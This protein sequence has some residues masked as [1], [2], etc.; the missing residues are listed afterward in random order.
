VLSQSFK[1]ILYLLLIYFVF[2]QYGKNIVQYDKFD[3]HFIQ[4]EHFDIYYSS[5]GEKNID[6]VASFS[7]EAYDKISNLIG[8]D[9]KHRSSII[10]YNSHNEFQQT[11]VIESYMREGIGGVTEL[12]KN[13]M[14]VPYDGSM[15]DFEQVIYHELVH[16]FINDGVYGG[17]LQSVINSNTVFIPL[18][19]NEGLA[20]YLSST[21]DTN[22][23]MWIRDLAINAKTLPEIKDLNG[24]FAYRGGQSLWKFICEK[25][26]EEVIAEIFYS[27]KV[28]KDINKGIK[29]ATGV[30][31]KEL[32]NQWHKYLKKEYWPDIAIRDDVQD[33][34]RQ[35]TDHTKLNN[36]YNIA[37]SPSP[38]GTKIAI[39][40]N[41]DGEMGIYI[42]SAVDG[43][44]IKRIVR[45]NRIGKFEELHF[46]KP[47]IS[48]SPEGENI[49]FSGKSDGDDA[50]FIYEIN[51]KKENFSIIKVGLKG[52][53]KPVWNPKNNKIAFIGNNGFSSDVYVYDLDT[54][55]LINLTNDHFSDIQIAWHPNGESLLLV[56]D[57]QNN[58]FNTELLDLNLLVDYNFD[59][60]DIFKIN[61][62]GEIDRI[63]DTPYNESYAT[64]SPNG[65]QIAYLSD[66]SGIN[67]IY[68]ISEDEEK[69]KPATNVSTGI[70][71]L[72][73]L[74]NNKLVFT[75]F[76]DSAYDIFILS[77]IKRALQEVK[78]VPLAKWRNKEKLKLLRKSNNNKFDDNN[79]SNF[80]F[81]SDNLANRDNAISFDPPILKDNQGKYK[82]YKYLT[83]F[84]LDYA[85]AFY[86]FDSYYG[87]AGMG[88]FLFSDILGDHRAAVGIELQSELEESD[89]F[90][91][92]RYLKKKLNHEGQLYNRAQKT[93]VTSGSSDGSPFF[94]NYV[95][96][97]NV[98]LDYRASY[99]FS[100]F[101]RLEGGINYN[102]YMRE[103]YTWVEANNEYAGYNFSDKKIILPYAK[104]VFDNTRWFYIHPV[105]GSRIYVK[106]DVA[107]GN[108]VNNFNYNMLTFDSRSYFELSY[109]GKISLAARIYGGSSWGENK[110]KYAIGGVPWLASSDKD[111]ISV[112]Y[113][114]Y[115][116]N[117]D[118]DF[119][120]MNNFVLP[121]RGHELGSRYGNKALLMNFELRLPMLV[122]YFPAIEYLGQIFG[123]FFVDMGV[124]WDDH[125]PKYNDRDSWDEP[126]GPEIDSIGDPI[127]H[128]DHAAGWVMSYG[129]GPRFIFFGMPWKLDYAW[130]YDPYEGKKSERS[131][132]L[133]IG[134]DF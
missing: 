107:P 86:T 21:W 55:L 32:T 77:N 118:K 57:R 89:Y 7:E 11:N 87:S 36:S 48:W 42:L 67:N 26:G 105:S 80:I 92:Y 88:V 74:S 128:P 5:I 102:Y 60:L 18:W 16:V 130:Q 17:S 51:S 64:Y 90:I 13:R 113:E 8:W 70:S 56:S 27:I 83:R 132:Y 2:P 116:Y 12:M 91:Q 103:D 9:L 22:S 76:Y 39:Y 126:E 47:G 40:S 129:L 111:K 81:S 24:Y 110:R 95:L 28:K 59:N 66:K 72:N 98:G 79:L 31:L 73:W 23:D 123:V 115:L 29:A 10:F 54:K 30:D 20:E 3:W 34:A 53:F 85:R 99:P 46:L 6:L 25:W 114:D 4:T 100:R 117:N 41:R 38:D 120:Y 33:I 127:Y 15:K 68:I 119:Y 108:G 61:L 52:I 69:S 63:T 93:F 121:I 19:M 44:F 106:Y 134:L 124:A 37:P 133:S 104:F 62:D 1:K 82:K 58:L 109:T 14:V 122:Y 112:E 84:T 45:S 97:R 101:S 125:Y 131:W 75:G 49:V 78:E 35:I 50:L 43:K 71:Q 94:P 65:T 96:Y